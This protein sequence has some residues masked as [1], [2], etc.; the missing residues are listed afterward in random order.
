MG[1]V[2]TA[3]A[4]SKAGAGIV[5]NANA[6]P[7]SRGTH[8]KWKELSSHETWACLRRKNGGRGQVQGSV[9]TCT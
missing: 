8:S 7:L 1:A 4:S 9:Q 3:K 2:R 6:A 5:K